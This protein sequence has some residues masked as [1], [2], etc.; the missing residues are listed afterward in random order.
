MLMLRHH[1][2]DNTTLVRCFGILAL[3]KDQ[4]VLADKLYRLLFDEDPHTLAIFLLDKCIELKHVPPLISF[5]V[6]TYSM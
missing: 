5:Q 4:V 3:G 6:Q 1:N 2:C